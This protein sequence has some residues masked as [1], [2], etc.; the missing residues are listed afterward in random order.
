MPMLI[1]KTDYIRRNKNFEIF[2]SF[3]SNIKLMYEKFFWTIFYEIWFLLITQY[4]QYLNR[5]AT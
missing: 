3:F 5:N 1:I 4:V 2:P